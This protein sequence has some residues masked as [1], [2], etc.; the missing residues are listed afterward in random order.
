MNCREAEKYVYLYAELNPREREKTDRHI[1]TCAACRELMETANAERNMIRPAARISRPLQD[2]SRMTRRIMDAV[3]TQQKRSV[4]DEFVAEPSVNLL[5]YSMVAI[6]LFIVTVFASEYSA[7]T[8][9]HPEPQSV[10]RPVSQ[11]V[12][13]NSASFRSALISKQE[14]KTT[15]KTFFHEC[16][17]N[18]LYAPDGDCEGCR[19]QIRK[20]N[21]KP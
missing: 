16:V 9:F 20:H 21:Q 12:E 14:N 15:T 1:S 11:Y 13:L 10:F 3:Q 4:F 6:S 18:C 8:Q 2:A 17:V 19:K 5:R 7:G